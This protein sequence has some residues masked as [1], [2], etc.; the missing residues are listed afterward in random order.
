MRHPKSTCPIQPKTPAKVH[1]CGFF[2][3]VLSTGMRCGGSGRGWTEICAHL[4]GFVGRSFVSVSS[5]CPNTRCRQTPVISRGPR[6]L[7]TRSPRRDSFSL[8][9]F[10]AHSVYLSGRSCPT[11]MPAANRN[12]TRHWDLQYCVW[13]SSYGTN[14]CT[15]ASGFQ[16]P[17]VR[18][19]AFC[20]T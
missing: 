3:I 6:T 4:D 10:L 11:L 7:Q 1:K 5:R 19:E 9:V 17:H 14:V 13:T 2:W 20:V 12:A 16:P 15:I 18:N 8:H